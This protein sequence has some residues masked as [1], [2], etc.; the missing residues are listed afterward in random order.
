MSAFFSKLFTLFLSKI[1]K[2]AICALM[3]KFQLRKLSCALT[4]YENAVPHLRNCVATE[5]K[6]SLRK[7]RCDSE[8]KKLNCAFCA[9]F[10]LVE[11]IVA[12]YY[13]ALLK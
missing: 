5:S 7:L 9:T 2:I 4:W 6:S 10:L 1:A 3:V 8:I 11:K 13:A 12:L